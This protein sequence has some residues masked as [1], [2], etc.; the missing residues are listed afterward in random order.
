[1]G[2]AQWTRW[3]RVM[4]AISC[5]TTRKDEFMWDIKEKKDPHCPFLILIITP[6]RNDY[7]TI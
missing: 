2:E 1:M 5:L 3:S 6:P 7:S 4:D